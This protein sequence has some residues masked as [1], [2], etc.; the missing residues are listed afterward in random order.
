MTFFPSGLKIGLVLS[1]I[2]L[3]LFILILWGLRHPDKVQALRARLS[4]EKAAPAEEAEEAAE[5]AAEPVEEPAVSQMEKWLDEQ[6]AAPAEEP[7]EES[8]E[9]AE[10]PADE[11][12]ETQS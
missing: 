4:R 11:S 6:V 8:A 12:A 3:V 1:G 7:A 10:E 2:G 9:P 5:E